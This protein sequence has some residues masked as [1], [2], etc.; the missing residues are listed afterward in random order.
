MVS[1]GA[2]QSRHPQSVVRTLRIPDDLNNEIVEL[3]KSR[4]SSFNEL[5]KNAIK[6]EIMIEKQK[7]KN[8]KR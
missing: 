6:K 4:S 7:N 5:M 8:K 1:T 3:Q 2:K